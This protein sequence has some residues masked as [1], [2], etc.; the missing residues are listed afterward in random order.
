M[1]KIL[2][3]Y[4][5]DTMYSRKLAEMIRKRAAVPFDAVS[6]DKGD[7]LLEFASRHKISV[8]LMGG[9]RELAR[10][11][12]ADKTIFL[13][14]GREVLAK[15][16]GDGIYK[17]Q[18]CDAILREAMGQYSVLD[19]SVTQ[20]VRVRAKVR[21]I[22]SPIN[23]CMKTSLAVAMGRLLAQ[24]APA[25][26]ISLETMSGYSQ[27][28]KE[29][30]RHD[31]SDMLY[32]SASGRFSAVRLGSI[33]RSM[34]GL[35]YLPPVRCPED[36]DLKCTEALPGLIEHIAK[37]SAYRNVVIDVG[38]VRR[39]TMEVLHECDTVYMPVGRDMVSRARI[40][41][42]EDYLKGHGHRRIYERLKK[43]E[44]P[45]SM[46]QVSSKSYWEGLLW[47]ELGRYTMALLARE[48][49]QDERHAREKGLVV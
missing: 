10:Q 15:G 9:D 27:L 18:S 30:Y 11:V 17:F 32:Y 29:E 16:T 49:E 47:G 37:G 41:E 24:E 35:D 5:R 26:L 44:L 23:R 42:F 25:L 48:R 14:D 45:V 36:L 28:Y 22:F 20:C 34:G 46:P 8:L 40:K 4:D 7:Q 43:V 33:V 31:L 38:A 6:F 2:A 12:R 39:G 13:E 1:K 19:E 3:I 21:G